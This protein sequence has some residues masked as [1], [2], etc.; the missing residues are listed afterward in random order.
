MPSDFS[1][2]SE[3]PKVILDWKYKTGWTKKDWS[4]GNS[5]F[6]QLLH[7]WDTLWIPDHLWTPKTV[8]KASVGSNGSKLKFLLFIPEPSPFVSCNAKK[9]LLSE[10]FPLVL[11]RI[12]LPCTKQWYSH[13]EL[14]RRH[15]EN[16]RLLKAMNHVCHHQ[17]GGWCGSLLRSHKPLGVMEEVRADLYTHKCACRHRCRL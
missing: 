17:R 5:S 12:C 2:R 7:F 14:T 13:G 1:G 8:E 4:F 15:N 3:D 6:F 9:T 16:K 10:F 11:A